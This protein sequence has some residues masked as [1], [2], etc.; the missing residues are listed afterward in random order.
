MAGLWGEFED[1]ID[2]RH[3][4]AS[5]ASSSSSVSYADQESLLTDLQSLL[6]DAPS[7]ADNVATLGGDSTQ[8]AL[9]TQL[10]AARS[11]YF[12]TALC[13][14][15]RRSELSLPYDDVDAFSD[16]L[17]FIYTGAVRLESTSG[18]AIKV[19]SMARYFDI[20]DLGDV[21]SRHIHD[22]LSPQSFHGLLTECI[23]VSAPAIPSDLT[24]ILAR[25]AA[26]FP[27]RVLTC[28]SIL[29]APKIE[30][31]KLA[32]T[33]W[34]LFSYFL[35][36]SGGHTDDAP[37]G[38]PPWLDSGHFFGSPVAAVDALIAWSTRHEMK[39][40]C[41][42]GMGT[43]PQKQDDTL[44]PDLETRIAPCAAPLANILNSA[45]SAI[46][47]TALVTVLTAVPPR[48]FSRLVEPLGLLNSEDVVAKY[49]TDA[50][51]RPFP[52]RSLSKIL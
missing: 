10:L 12:A 28:G 34:Y 19:A 17:E 39:W 25:Y 21:A 3:R 45:G 37:S 24:H 51:S 49:R 41:R 42:V 27:A 4:P 38:S 22:S 36:S 13:R 33:T 29:E 2:A 31:E 16:V 35:G 30:A 8:I 50:L 32:S 23:S 7:I 15:W 14:P 5:C 46:C 44:V 9:H 11:S 18:S 20:D 48:T 6:A 47:R 40:N 52:R 43:C 26:R 1:D